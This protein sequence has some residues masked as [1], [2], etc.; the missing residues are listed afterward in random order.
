MADKQSRLAD[1]YKAEKSKGGGIA[2]TLGKRALE[3]MDPRQF[4]NQK[5]FM[6]TA[7]P[8]LFKSY[9]ATPTKS[10]G[11]IASLGGGSFSSGVLETKLDILTGETRELKIH[12]KIAAKNSESLPIMAR[13]MNLMRQNIT[14]LVKLQG[15]TAASRAD[16]FFMKSGEKETAYENR[17]IKEGG[18]S[19]TPTPVGEKPKE[20]K[21]GIFATIM[22][23]LSSIFSMKGLLIAGI[24]AAI[25]FGIK[26]YFT[27]DDFKLKV[28][29][30][31]GDMFTTIKNYFMEKLP[32]IIDFMRDHWKELAVAFALLFPKTT[33]DLIA[34]GLNV[35][36][37]TITLLATAI[38][39][40]LPILE[41]ALVGAFR[42]LVTLLSGPAGLIMLL[43]GA[44]FSARKL[45]DQNQEEYLK[46]AKEKKEKG[47][48]SEKDEARLKELSTPV[49]RK[50]AQQDLKYDPTTGKAVSDEEAAKSMEQTTSDTQTIHKRIEE[51]AFIQLANEWEKGG[52][53]DPLLN[54]NDRRNVARR[55]EELKAQGYVPK[56]M[57]ADVKVE[58]SGAPS[59]LPNETAGGAAVGLYPTP[60][61]QRK[62]GLNHGGRTTQKLVGGGVDDERLI[63]PDTPTPAS[64][65]NEGKTRPAPSIMPNIPGSSKETSKT[66]TIEKFD[67]AKYKELVGIRE[68]G[69]K[70]DADNKV[71]FIGKYQF[72][73]Q[74][75]ETFKYLK[76]GTSADRNAVYSPSN[77]TGKNGISSADDFKKASDIQENLMN[78]YTDM[79]LKGLQKSGVLTGEDSG[80]AVAA[81]LYAAH[82]GGVGGASKFFKENKDTADFAFS[83][84]SVGKSAALMA[85]AYETGQIGGAEYS[86]LGGSS[87]VVVAS[88]SAPY[89]APG[90]Q[91]ASSP[92]L[93]MPTLGTLAAAA[94]TMGDMIDSATST[95]TDALRMF[96]SA[97]SS[98]TNITNNN[99]Q[100]ST[101]AQQSQGNLPSVYDDVFL[102]LFQRV[103]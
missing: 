22:D 19:K 11:K 69:G 2:S 99:T 49:N 35:L 73:A 79:N 56:D 48:L 47:S 60:G 52:K 101:S 81:K 93:K 97:L 98:I 15:G 71:G 82:H 38:K 100:T 18:K 103:S 28:D 42:G 51:A 102:S 9:S 32:V 74:A 91:S 96:D 14:K 1:I 36:S 8:S 33:M 53:K 63:K 27:N 17:F 10:G 61:M 44:L 80:S 92:E 30:F 34:G 31:L 90:S 37:S 55:T 6:A 16:M 72:G 26:E 64:Y 77:W 76:P 94:P 7:L 62:P 41:V 29:S 59:V 66:P 83:G 20:E 67:Y 70:Y 12:S 46:L 75:L 21:K 87:G 89:Q 65:S 84:A 40:L 3:K 95:F 4:F 58:G 43:G 88:K 24:L 45:F 50:K 78:A 5:G 86:G 68:G 54:P 13:D 85:T 25:T 39:T 57:P 23:G